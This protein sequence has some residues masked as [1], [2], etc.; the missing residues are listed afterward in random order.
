MVIP[1]EVDHLS[2]EE[3]NACFR[4]HPIQERWS[5]LT[6]GHQSAINDT[7]LARLQ[8]IPEIGH[9]KVFSDQITD[10]GVKHLLQLSGLTHLVLYSSGV[11]DECLTDIKKMKSLVSL[12]VQ[13]ASGISRTAVLNSINDMPWLQ[14]AW[15]PPDPAHLAECQRR[16]GLSQVGRNDPSQTS[17]PS[18]T[19]LRFVNLS[20]KPM[21]RPPDEVFNRDDIYRLDLI[22]CGVE[23]LPDEIGNLTELPNY[24]RFT[25]TG[26]G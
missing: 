9:V 10:A 7:D 8:H 19:P 12:D 18:S 14:D 6:I 21:K 4:R 5:I 17:P 25:P 20:H 16:S 3:A 22:D 2:I 1:S 23:M 24:G 13:S 11:T 15:P 26:V